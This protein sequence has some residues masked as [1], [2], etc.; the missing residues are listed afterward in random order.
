MLYILLK[1]EKKKKRK[2][3]RGMLASDFAKVDFK[4]YQDLDINICKNVKV[5]LSRHMWLQ[6]IP[7]SKH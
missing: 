3:I 5:C 6:Y 1:K 2:R 4:L 7:K